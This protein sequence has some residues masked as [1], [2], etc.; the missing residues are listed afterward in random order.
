[1][2]ELL[3]SAASPAA[4][5]RE[6]AALLSDPERRTRARRELEAVVGTLGPPGASDRTARMVLE[7]IA[8]AEG[9]RE[10]AC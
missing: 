4:M 2:R 1:V 7:L 8:G 3:G 6:A 10:P 9:G 5:A